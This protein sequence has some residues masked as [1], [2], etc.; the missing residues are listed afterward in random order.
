MPEIKHLQQYLCFFGF[1][2]WLKY[3][4]LLLYNQ[5]EQ[6][7]IHL[8]SCS[9]ILESHDTHLLLDFRFDSEHVLPIRI[10]DN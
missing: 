2:V 3:D 5:F 7:V 6:P 9:R 1:L 4:F 8:D 10:G